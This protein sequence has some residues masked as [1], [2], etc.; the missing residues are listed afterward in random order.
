MIR[1]FAG[2]RFGC[3]SFWNTGC[4]RMALTKKRM[5]LFTDW[6]EPGYKAG[7]PIQSC[8]NIVGLL[9]GEVDFYIVTSDRDLG[10]TAAY[11]GIETDG[12]LLKDDTNIYYSSPGQLTIKKIR[13]IFQQVNPDVVYLNSMFSFRYTIMPLRF[14]SKTAFTGKI[15]LAPRGMLTDS[16]LAIKKWKKKLYILAFSKS[17]ISRKIVFHATSKQEIT[18]IKKAIGDRVNVFFAPNVPNISEPLIEKEKRAGQLNCIYLSRIHPIKNLQ[19]ALEV[20]KELGDL[21]NIRFDIFGPV[22]DEKYYTKCFELARRLEK[23]IEVNFMGSLDRARLAGTFKDYHLFFLPTKGE[24]FG[25]AIF[26]ALASG[27]PV[28]IS[29]QTPWRDIQEYGA[30]W[31]LPLASTTTFTDKILEA[32]AMGEEQFNSMSLNARK[33]AE[34]YLATANIKQQYSTLFG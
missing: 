6:Y 9:S 12:W 19:F 29:D 26:E 5:L 14:L 23:N 31:A 11:T 30:G 33:Y 18:D 10:D 17:A 13:E 20:F 24:N 2:W 3:S 32:C 22:E 8:R 4:K 7:G 25:H 16:A 34:K 15:V 1:L 27:C 28:L 21:H